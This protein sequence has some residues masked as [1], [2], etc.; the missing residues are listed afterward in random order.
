M[1]HKILSTGTLLL[2]ACASPVNAQQQ[3][4]NQAQ[5]APG[6]TIAKSNRQ[7]QQSS[8]SRQGGVYS[9]PT[10]FKGAS[11]T[12]YQVG[13]K[14]A[15]EGKHE[16]AIKAFQKV[17]LIDPKNEDAYFSLGNVY[18]D[19]ERWPEAAER[20]KQALRLKPK[21]AEA[22]NKLGVAYFKMNDYNRAVESFKQA[23]NLIPQWP[24]PRQHLSDAYDK[25]GQTVAPGAAP[26]E[27][28]RIQPAV[29]SPSINRTATATIHAQPDNNATAKTDHAP[30]ATEIKKD[31]VPTPVAAPRETVSASNDAKALYRQGVKYGRAGQLVR[32]V[33]AFQQA[34]KIKK[35]YADAY[36]ALGHAYS[37]LGQWQQAVE[38]Y[39]QVVR[40]DPKDEEA[41]TKLGIAY[42]K[43]RAQKPPAT[44]AANNTGGAKD[45]TANATG[46]ITVV[47]PTGIYRVGVGDVLDV[48]QLNS[49][50]RES[51]LYTVSAGGLLEYPLLSEPLKVTGLTT[52]EI[53][54]LLTSELKRRTTN[55]DNKIVVGV[56]D[57]DSHT[58]IV[59]GLVKDPGSKVIRREAIPLYV[60]TA[61]AQPLDAARRAEIIERA[62]KGERRIINLNDKAAMNTLIYP[63]D[64][65]NVLPQAPQV[66]QFFYIGGR[67]SAPGKKDFHQGI[68]LTQAVLSAGHALSEKGHVN[69]ARRDSSGLLTTVSYN[70]K[71]IV[72]GK[73][74]D[75]IVE[76]DDRI[77]VAP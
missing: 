29:A 67:V 21:D 1:V 56:R 42:A 5:T 19:M 68:T 26:T 22:H 46:A 73:I 44:I 10:N 2:L 18:S 59:S 69:V 48:R 32:A 23:A 34:I 74:P 25:L 52:D 45:I 50:S 43:I 71:D 70:L 35:D 64:V 17:I 24:E 31:A 53:A 6:V 55:A 4:N 28:P 30:I 58:I 33:T 12:Y 15:L 41:Y 57:Y 11:A 38:A 7:V 61:D 72:A 27:S 40:I 9:S 8:A 20:Y 13:T 51:T 3:T 39:E 75:P 49:N 76:P 37:D 36:F 63:G 60:V 77:E 14:Y 66:P 65:I 47:D 16:L 54:A 62:S